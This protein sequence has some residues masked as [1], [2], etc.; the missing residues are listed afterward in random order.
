MTKTVAASAFAALLFTVSNPAAGAEERPLTL[1]IER[2]DL[3]AAI[4]A[5]GGS[6]KA[7]SPPSSGL[8]P[9]EVCERHLAV[10]L[11]GLSHHWDG[12]NSPRKLEEVNTGAGI[13]FYCG[14][15]FAAV[16]D[17]K[18][19]VG[20]N[21]L[22]YGVGY[23]FLLAQVRKIAVSFTPQLTRVQ[24]EIPGYETRRGNAIFPAFSLRG[25]KMALNLGFIPR[26][27]RLLK[28][29]G[30][31]EAIFVFVSYHGDPLK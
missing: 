14:R 24:Y 17:M 25:E 9:L 20:G 29:L 3:L 1:K 16:D 6:P 28:L 30:K 23:E 13:R 2:Q 18:N 22:A 12:K 21:M 5:E 31:G 4:K 19:S 27:R 7:D 10:N 11:W 8:K 26:E 15:L